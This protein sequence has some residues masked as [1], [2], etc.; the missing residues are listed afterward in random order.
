MAHR[1]AH[2]QVPLEVLGLGFSRTGTS[3]LRDALEMLGY[4]VTNHGFR[5]G[6]NPT[7]RAMWTE[8]INAKFYGKGN[9]Y[10]RVEWDQLL[11]HCMAVTDVPHILFAE[12][13]IAAYPEAKVILTTR[14]PEDWWK[15]YS[16]T[17]ALHLRGSIGLERTP[18]WLEPR[19]LRNKRVFWRLVF[20]TLFGLKET[21]WEVTPEIAKERFIVHYEQVRRLVP[22]DRLLEHRVG[23]GWEHLCTFLGKPVPEMPFPKV[24][25]AGEY[26]SRIGKRN[27]ELL[28]W[29]IL[30]CFLFGATVLV[31]MYG[32]SLANTSQSVI[33]PERRS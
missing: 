20:R 12:D 6:P 13:L 23:E 19:Q 24:N 29:K 11:G 21:E 33:L 32:I 1:R 30:R 31:G 17:I 4:N 5:V 3:S 26:V 2:R 16:S 9:P 18:E 15:S 28:C 14:D 8:A 22:K 7:D 25:D 10:G 27:R